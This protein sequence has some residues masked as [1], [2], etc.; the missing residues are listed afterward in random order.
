ML[1][2][3]L[4]S[5]SFQSLDLELTLVRFPIWQKSRVSGLGFD[6]PPGRNS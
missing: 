5:G 4:V 2:G 3:F 1:G 6:L